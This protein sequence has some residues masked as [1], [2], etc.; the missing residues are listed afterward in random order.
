MTG[1]GLHALARFPD[2][3]GV[4]AG[5]HTDG[6]ASCKHSEHP[7]LMVRPLV[8]RCRQSRYCAIG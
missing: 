5:R 4:G 6:T 3:P 8:N 1:R 2:E 7:N